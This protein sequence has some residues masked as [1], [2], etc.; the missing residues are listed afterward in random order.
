MRGKKP[1]QLTWV[2]HKLHIRVCFE[3]LGHGQRALRVLLHAN[4]E[5]LQAPVDLIAVERRRHNARRI[6]QEQHSLVQ[7]VVVDDGRAHDHVTVPVDVLAQR[8]GHDVGAQL[9]RPLKVR[10]EERV[11]HDDDDIFGVRMGQLGD[12]LDIDD[13]HRWIG[14][15]F[16]PNHLIINTNCTGRRMLFE[17]EPRQGKGRY[18]SS[19]MQ[20]DAIPWCLVSALFS[21]R[22]DRWRR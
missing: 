13:L 18:I 22:S 12:A 17:C 10:G 20:F 6:L 3:I 21:A 9:E 14:R 16:D 8:I 1:R 5:R 2:Q 15:C 7:V 19:R 11:V 4:G